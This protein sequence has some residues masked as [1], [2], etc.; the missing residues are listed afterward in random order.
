[1]F[2]L[3][4]NLKELKQLNEMVSSEKVVVERDGIMIKMNGKM[5]V[6]EIILNSSLDIEKQQ[7]ILK[8]VFNEAI[9]KIQTAL[10]TKFSNIKF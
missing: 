2:N 1:M 9:K 7:K 10:M 6:E 8:D 4:K 3:F 5:E